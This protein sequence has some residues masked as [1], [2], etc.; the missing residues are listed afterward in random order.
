MIII[1]RNGDSV[2]FYEAETNT[3]LELFVH[4]NENMSFRVRNY[5]SDWT[6]SLEKIEITKIGNPEI[7]KILETFYTDTFFKY[8]KYEHALYSDPN[9]LGSVRK[10]KM[11]KKNAMI[12]TSCEEIIGN[13]NKTALIYTP[14]KFV[15]ASKYHSKYYM[16]KD[17]VIDTKNG[18]WTPFL[19]SFKS[20]YADA[21]V[22]AENQN[23][24]FK[25]MEDGKTI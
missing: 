23:K 13:H 14:E 10:K 9:V 20:L 18:E 2:T 8:K 24:K 6:N 25:E 17:V 22:L 19:R 1:Q 12:F 15:V 5:N 3:A 11:F 21:C 16:D 4:E 7:F